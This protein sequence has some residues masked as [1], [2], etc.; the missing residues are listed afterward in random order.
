MV[1]ARSPSHCHKGTRV[2]LRR[3]WPTGYTRSL[4][5]CRRSV[6][7]RRVAARA[8][9]VFAAMLLVP[10]ASLASVMV[11][12]S[13][14]RIGKFRFGGALTGRLTVDRRW[15]VLP[16]HLIV[17]GCQITTTSTDA[18]INF[19]NAKLKLKHHLVTLNGGS[20]GIAA[21]LDISVSQ[22][23]NTES[24]A[25]LNAPALV[26]FNAIIKGKAY[27]WHSNTTPT[28]RFKGG[29]TVSTNAHNTSGLVDATLI[30]GT[31]AAGHIDAAL[32]VKGSW[33]YCK[34][35]PG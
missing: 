12:G 16:G 1:R 20:N 18:D 10:V 24:L 5:T 26:T 32:T 14:G 29:G 22:N 23:G 21:E 8:L 7:T 2:T 3:K 9:G 11:T 19:F 31:P 13:G 4:R 15:T 28:S 35:F 25:G 6:V 34:R 27:E 33:S 30:P 17:A